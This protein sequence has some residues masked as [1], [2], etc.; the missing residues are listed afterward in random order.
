MV[1]EN[2]RTRHRVRNTALM[3]FP[4]LMFAATLTIILIQLSGYAGTLEDTQFGFN[5]ATIRNY[6]S[7]MSPEDMGL[8]VAANLV[9]YLFMLCYGIFFYST[10]RLISWNYKSGLPNKIGFSFAWIGVIAA[11][12]DGI[13]NVFLLSMAANP[14]GFVDWLAFAHSSF[15][16]VKFL[17]LYVAMAWTIVGF[18]INRTPLATY[19]KS[20][21]IV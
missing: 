6:F 21:Q 5:A 19:L 20:I 4:L 3:S 10:A 14:V 8:F 16:L 13:E 12:L 1:F 2:D 17:F 7:L 11:F 15:A 9:D 18:V